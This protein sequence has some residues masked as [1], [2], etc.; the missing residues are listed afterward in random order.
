[1]VCS[2]TAP[3]FGL[4]EINSKIN[5]DVTYLNCC[6]RSLQA[7]PEN[8]KHNVFSSLAWSLSLY[9]SRSCVCVCVLPGVDPPLCCTYSTHCSESFASADRP[10]GR[11]LLTEALDARW[12][13]WQTAWHY[14]QL[15]YKAHTLSSYFPQ[16]LN[17]LLGT[18]EVIQKMNALNFNTPRQS[19]SLVPRQNALPRGSAVANKVPRCVMT[20]ASSPILRTCRLRLTSWILSCN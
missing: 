17:G 14:R 16:A 11:P 4:L 13:F 18:V 10:T 9:L 20:T 12:A 3:L 5:V 8:K 1:M 15:A 19:G 2:T 7:Q 6:T